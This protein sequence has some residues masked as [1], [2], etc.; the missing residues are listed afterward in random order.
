MGFLTTI[1]KPSTRSPS[2]LPSGSFTV[3]PA[4]EIVTSTVSSSF[5]RESLKH[6]AA[7]V[8]L[9]FRDAKQADVRITEFTATLGSMKIKARELRGGAIIFLTPRNNGKR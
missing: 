7:A 2:P 3:D 8:L 1:F 9:A 6:V 5:T 4:G